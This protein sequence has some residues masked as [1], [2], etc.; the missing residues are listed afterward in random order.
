VAAPPLADQNMAQILFWE[1]EEDFDT[2]A[3]IKR[4]TIFDLSR[5]VSATKASSI[6]AASTVSL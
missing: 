6:C 1:V 2:A 5:P 3:W 4:R